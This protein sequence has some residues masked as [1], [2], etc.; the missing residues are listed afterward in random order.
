MSF[1]KG[2]ISF[3]IFYLKNGLSESAIPAF[4][5]H[6]APPLDTLGASPVRGWV[7]WRHLLDRDVSEQACYVSPWYRV[8]A[9]QAEKKVPPK[10]LKAYC[11][12]EEDVVMRAENLA[13]L[14]RKQKAEIKKRVYEQLQPQM[15]PTLTGLPMVANLRTNF[16]LAEA[17]TSANMDKFTLLFRETTDEQPYVVTPNGLAILRKQVNANDLA[18]AVFTDDATVEPDDACDLG[19]EFLTWLWFRFEQDGCA[20]QSRIGAQC[21]CLLEGPVTFFREGKGAHEAVLRKGD[22][23]RSP[24]AA[25]AILCGKKMRSVK[26]SLAIGDKAWT[27]TLDATFAIRGLKLPKDPENAHPPFE[28]RMMDVETFTNTLFDLFDLFLVQRADKRAWTKCEKEIR[29][30]ARRRANEE[31]APGGEE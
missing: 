31:Q 10:L 5:G 7:S 11:L 12:Q 6:A 17:M 13:F 19:R 14:N 30:W 23:L 27:A 2:N 24:E 28:E 3:R 18:P 22:P 26:F 4:A 1:D 21:S 9:L 16:V 20:F 29:A 8:V 25:L 15:P